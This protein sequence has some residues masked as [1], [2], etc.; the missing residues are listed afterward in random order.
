MNGLMRC[1]HQYMALRR[2][3]GQD[4][5]GQEEADAA[6]DLMTEVQRRLTTT[7]PETNS[8]LL[9][10][11]LFIRQRLAEEGGDIVPPDLVDPLIE[12]LERTSGGPD[13]L[14]PLGGARP[15]AARNDPV[16]TV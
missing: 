7:P 12:V 11:A 9:A 3:F 5:L 2:L 14:C 13:L 10:L 6:D 16:A 4:D 1:Y 15:E 8:D